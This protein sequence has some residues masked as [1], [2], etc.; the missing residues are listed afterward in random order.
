METFAVSITFTFGAK[1]YDTA[2]ELAERIG[3]LVQQEDLTSTWSIIDIEEIGSSDDEDLDF[4]D[5]E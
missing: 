2:I 4:E 3:A 1:D 5:D